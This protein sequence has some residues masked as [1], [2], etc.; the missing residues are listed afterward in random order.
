MRGRV[1][2]RV[3][4]DY[5]VAVR[6][7]ESFAFAEDLNA[8]LRP[9]AE[10][11]RRAALEVRAVRAPARGLCGAPFGQA[12]PRIGDFDELI[13]PGAFSAT[14]RDGHDVSRSLDHDHGLA[15]RAARRLARCGSKKRGR[16]FVFGLDLPDTTGAE[17]RA[18][19]GRARATAGGMRFAFG[20]RR[21]ERW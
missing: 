10:L 17:R 20:S 1:S 19:A 21:G 4:R 14:L 5:D 11:E 12:A 8:G 9:M 3:M 2:V 13:A 15:A 16:R 6:H 18:G 7:A